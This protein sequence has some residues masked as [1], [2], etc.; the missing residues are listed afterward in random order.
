MAI[1]CLVCLVSFAQ[2]VL[3]PT[4]TPSKPSTVW[5]SMG[6]GASGTFLG[7]HLASQDHSSSSPMQ[8]GPMCFA[9]SDPHMCRDSLQTG[10]V[11]G[12]FC[13]ILLYILYVCVVVHELEPTSD[14]SPEEGQL[15]LEVGFWFLCLTGYLLLVTILL[16]TTVQLDWFTG[17]SLPFLVGISTFLFSAYCF[18][19]SVALDDG[20]ARPSP[21]TGAARPDNPTWC[22]RW[23]LSPL[24]R[25]EV[26]GE[27]LQVVSPYSLLWF[28]HP[29][30][31]STRKIKNWP[32]ERTR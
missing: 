4:A 1:T 29:G 24:W 27:S 32:T 16:N 14:Q 18:F 28:L 8:A 7:W 21:S 11:R 23:L 12:I 5:T 25:Q 17:S 6:L 2:W 19:P 13:A 30:A 22:L 15:S 9:H 3:T 20:R 31:W 10:Y 26:C